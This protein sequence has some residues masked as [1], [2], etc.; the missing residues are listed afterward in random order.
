SILTSKTV[1]NLDATSNVI[2]STLAD[3]HV[4]VGN[5]GGGG[6]PTATTIAS[7]TNIT[8]TSGAGAISVATLNNPVFSTSTTTPVV[9]GGSAAGS[10][11]NLQS[12]SNGSPSAD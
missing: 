3:G 5:S 12:T 6:T 11:L 2:S 10:S 8:V 7:E 1:L 4:L 9:Y